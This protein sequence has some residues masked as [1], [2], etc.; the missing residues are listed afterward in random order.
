MSPIS[1]EQ[2]LSRVVG[3]VRPLDPLRVATI[4]ALGLVLT[5]PVRS[6]VDLPGFD[7]SAMDGYAVVAADLAGATPDAPVAL[8]V[9][10]DIPAGDT[11]RHTLTAGSCWRIM[12]G[13]PVPEGA[14]AVVQVELTDAGVQRVQVR[15]EVAVGTAVRRAG[16]DVRKGDLVLDAGVRLLPHHIA[17]C[18]AAGAADVEVRP[19]PRVAVITTGDELVP[20]GAPLRH[21]Q[22][23]DSNGPMLAAAVRACGAVVA[24]LVHVGDRDDESLADVVRRV[25]G[26][27][28]A[29][30]TSG[31]ISAG[32]YEPVKEAFASGDAV[33]FDS[34]AMQPGKP[35]GFGLVGDGVPLFALPGNPVSSLVSFETFVVPALRCMAGRDQARVSWRASVTRG[36]RSPAGRVQLARVLLTR[37][38][39]GWQVEPSGAQG[40]H[41]LGGLAAANA[42]AVIAADVDV[43]REGDEVDVH[44][45]PGEEIPS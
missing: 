31:G 17:A 45:L 10:G 22:I 24:S 4:D 12:T 37:S 5:A 16:E 39:G 26:D 34:V 33:R 40:S 9:L 19:A 28:D 44:L 18:V 11:E 13:A 35:Q 14:D 43:V 27:A 25:A 8:P 32:A 15:A 20:V 29:I 1:V 41:I 38:A 7:N 42:I 23:H 21:G 36:W 3:T 6:A 2:H 30:V